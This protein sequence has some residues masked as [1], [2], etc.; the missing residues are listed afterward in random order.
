L[1]GIAGGGETGAGDCRVAACNLEK[2]RSRESSL[3]VDSVLFYQ[4]M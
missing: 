4:F 3:M 1:M 2:I